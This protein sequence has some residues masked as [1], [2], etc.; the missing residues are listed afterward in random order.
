MLRA[1]L[2][3]AKM[4]SQIF[5]NS[6]PLSRHQTQHVPPSHMLPLLFPMGHKS[7][8]RSS[9]IAPS[10][11]LPE[12]GSIFVYVCV[13]VL[14]VVERSFSVIPY[15]YW[16][17]EGVKRVR[18][19]APPPIWFCWGRNWWP[20]LHSCSEYFACSIMVFG[21]PWTTISTEDFQTFKE[22]HRAI[23][24][25]NT[26]YYKTHSSQWRGRTLW[27]NSGAGIRNHQMGLLIQWLVID[28]Q[29]MTALS[30]GFFGC[31]CFQFLSESWSETSLRKTAWKQKQRFELET[32]NNL[33]K[34]N[35]SFLTSQNIYLSLGLG[36]LRTLSLSSI[37]GPLSLWLYTSRLS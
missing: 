1:V 14:M 37:S 12:H 35:A 34:E 3:Q 18:T 8:S 17:V 5:I 25:H 19:V 36:V 16:R 11:L 29:D 10:N 9:E 28:L 26:V 15:K 27:V 23:P 2:L 30:A 31:V 24:L 21:D 22:C 6:T 33:G 4:D 7:L 13:C 20:A 32:T